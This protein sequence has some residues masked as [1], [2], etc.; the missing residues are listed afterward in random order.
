MNQ[1]FKAAVSIA[2]MA[3][4]SGLSRS[5]FYQLIGTAFP[6][7]TRDEAGR[8]YY[9][10]EQQRVCMEVR[11]RNYGIDGKPVLFYAPR[12]STPPRRA[13]RTATVKPHAEIIEGVKALGLS[14]VTDAQVDAAIAESFPNGVA[15]VDPGELIRAVFLSIRRKNSSGNDGR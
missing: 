2:E 15:G 5:R 10:E 14:S 4:M 7:P 3:R 8:P 13:P 12:S 11:R 1:Q 9:A 6:E